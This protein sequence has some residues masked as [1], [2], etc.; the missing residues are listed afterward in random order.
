MGRLIGIAKAREKLAPMQE[1][2]SAFV[3]VEAGIED[4]A[5]GRNTDRQVTV[6]FRESWKSACAE[7]HADVPWTARRANLLVEGVPTPREGARI[8]VGDVV[9]QV[10]KE[11]KPCHMMDAAHQGLKVA[12]R[13]DWRGGVCCNVIKSGTISVG[14]AVSVSDEIRDRES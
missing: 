7:L 5:R 8:M 9:L 13:P 12:L 3:S 2:A 6:L 4:D 10:T 11:T 14:D 1:V